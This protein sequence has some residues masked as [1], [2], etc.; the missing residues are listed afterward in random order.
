MHESVHFYSKLQG[1][2][3]SGTWRHR[4]RKIPFL[5]GAA[6]GRGFGHA[7]VGNP[8]RN[9]LST[10]NSDS[11]NTSHTAIQSPK[12]IGSRCLQC[13]DSQKSSMGMRGWKARPSIP[14]RQLALDKQLK[15]FVRQLRTTVV[16]WTQADCFLS[17]QTRTMRALGGGELISVMDKRKPRKGK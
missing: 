15:R 4:R 14:R 12:V 16:L 7:S 8:E 2:H 6:R 1:S 5:S 17:R 13:E 9:A 10:R 11:Q 3:G